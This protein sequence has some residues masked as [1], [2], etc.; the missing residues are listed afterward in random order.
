M[1]LQKLGLGVDCSFKRFYGPLLN[2]CI[3]FKTKGEFIQSWFSLLADPAGPSLVGSNC[4][5]LKQNPN[6]G[7]QT[8]SFNYATIQTIKMDGAR[9]NKNSRTKEKFCFVIFYI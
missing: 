6:A 1:C 3:T 9:C 8:A 5:L 4:Y 2:V 7:H